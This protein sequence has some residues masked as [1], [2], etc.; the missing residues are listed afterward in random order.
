MA[1]GLAMVGIVYGDRSLYDSAFAY[2]HHALTIHRRLVDRS[3]AAND[4]RFLGL[5]F[6]HGTKQLDSAV[7]YLKQDYEDEFAL[8]SY[9]LAGGTMTNIGNACLDMAEDDRALGSFLQAYHCY[10]LA[11]D[12]AESLLAL[13]LQPAYRRVGEAVFVAACRAQQYGQDDIDA[14]LARLK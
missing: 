4:C 2:L 5:S 10:T 13:H 1:A 8:G 11:G 12:A 7:Y 6:Q 9:R 14:L 3:G